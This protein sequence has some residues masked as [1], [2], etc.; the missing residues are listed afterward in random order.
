MRGNKTRVKSSQRRWISYL[1]IERDHEV[2][3]DWSTIS[4]IF[5]GTL[6]GVQFDLMVKEDKHTD[7]YIIQFMLLSRY[8]YA[9]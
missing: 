6:F 7:H 9:E 8:C 1:I 2:A 4:L 3:I 5:Q